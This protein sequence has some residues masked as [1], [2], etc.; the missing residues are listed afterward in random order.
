[1]KKIYTRSVFKFDESTGQYALDHNESEFHLVAD[2]YPVAL[3]KGGDQ[4]TQV[5]KTAPWE[6]QQPY[7]TK[8][9]QGAQDAFLGD[10]GN[11]PEGAANDMLN[12]TLRGD[13][14][15]GGEGFNKALDAAK[16]KIIP[17]VQSGF[18]SR[19]RSGSGLAGTAEAG[20]I[21]DSFSKLYEQERQNQ[22]KAGQ[23]AQT[24]M[25][26]RQR[27]LMAYMQT[28]GGNYGGTTTTS[29]PNKGL[30]GWARYLAGAGGG[31]L[32]GASIGSAVPG[33]G[34]GIGAGVGGLL[35]LLGAYQ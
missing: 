26:P 5:T 24:S 16:N 1:M 13:Y 17:E 19:G 23:L 12:A 20:A 25:N 34:T 3:M 7:I 11:A 28:I 35:G 33:I 27:A 10:L 2:D 22:L 6:G 21:G 32:S 9:F 8:G 30:S 31:A 15:T 18:A 29:E 14:L 4:T